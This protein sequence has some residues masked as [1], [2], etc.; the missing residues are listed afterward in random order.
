MGGCVLRCNRFFL[1]VKHATNAGGAVDARDKKGEKERYNIAI[2]QKKWPGVF[3]I[4]GRRKGAADSE[5]TMNWSGYGK[6]DSEGKKT[7]RGPAAEKKHSL[8][9]KKVQ[10]VA[11]KTKTKKATSKPRHTGNFDPDAVLQYTKVDGKADYIH[12][13]CKRLHKKTVKQCFGLTY[14]KNGKECKYGLS[15]L[16]YDINGGSLRLSK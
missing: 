4:N 12:E 7:S 1:T 14:M 8:K 13:R 3:R 2:L 16:R 5:V 11:L 10:K 15:D 9:I 6:S